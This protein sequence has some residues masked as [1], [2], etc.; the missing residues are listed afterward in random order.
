MYR[1][2]KQ[3]RRGLS[4]RHDEDEQIHLISPEDDEEETDP[5][6]GQLKIGQGSK[7]E[8]FNEVWV[9]LCVCMRID[10]SSIGFF[11]QLWS[12]TCVISA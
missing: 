9:I 6:E 5:D 2:R 10:V 8:S 3:R 11:G 12:Y 1:A 4:I 7:K